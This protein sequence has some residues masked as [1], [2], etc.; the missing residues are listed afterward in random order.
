MAYLKIIRPFNLF[1][2]FISQLILKLSLSYL[3][4]VGTQL[5]FLEFATLSFVTLCIA[6]AGYI[7]NDIVD[8]KADRINKPNE[9][10]VID[11]ISLRT[12]YTYCISLWTIG[13]ILGIYSSFIL[14]CWE[15]S[16]LFIAV[17]VALYTYNS[18]FQRIPIL[19]NVVTSGL[20]AFSLVIIWLFEAKALE[21]SGIER[22]LIKEGHTLFTF[23]VVLA[24]MINVL[25]ELV[26]DV[27]D[28]NGDYAMEYRTLPI[29]IGSK[30]TMLLCALIALGLLFNSALFTFIFAG[31]SLLISVVLFAFTILPLGYVA[32][33]CWNAEKTSDYKYIA[34]LLK[35][36]MLLGIL[37]FPLILIIERYA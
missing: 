21:M 37:L 19:G 35:G 14:G 18:Y 23:V 36:I 17:S 15:Y 11:N 10:Y 7:H 9:V 29:I 20:V 28:I 24:F 32:S 22:I 31:G 25:R 12:A 27:Q 30:R 1:M 4:D 16:L 2:I 3:R 6:A 5:S 8:I 33:Q 13:I 26:K 34:R